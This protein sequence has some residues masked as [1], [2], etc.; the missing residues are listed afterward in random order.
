MDFKSYC[1]ILNHSCVFPANSFDLHVLTLQC[2]TELV[3]EWFV[4]QLFSTL[5]L[6]PLFVWMGVHG[7][8]GNQ[9]LCLLHGGAL[10]TKPELG[11]GRVFQ[12]VLYYTQGKTELQ[13]LD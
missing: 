2:S 5:L 11:V 7:E 9:K 12:E 8:K 13:S 1:Y 6:P 10:K 3:I 4:N